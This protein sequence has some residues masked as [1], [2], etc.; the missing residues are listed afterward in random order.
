MK[1]R[2]E[3]LSSIFF[4]KQQSY[5]YRLYIEKTKNFRRKNP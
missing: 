1:N 4:T 2:G 3:N 5:I